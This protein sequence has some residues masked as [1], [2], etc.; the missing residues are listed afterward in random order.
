M[1]NATALPDPI[2]RR[3]GSAAAEEFQVLL[4][5]LDL[6]EGFVLI[7]LVVP[8]NNG[9]RLC[10]TALT[11][12]LAARDQHLTVIAPATPSDLNDAAATLLSLPPDPQRGAIWL[13]A[14]A[15]PWD[16]AYPAWE[17]A[18]R[19]ALVGLN[20]ARNPL[21][22][23][24]PLPVILVGTAALIPQMRE[25]AAD[26]W[27]VRSLSLRIEPGPEP[28][29]E[30]REPA[31]PANWPEPPIPYNAPDPDLALRMADRLSGQDSQQRTVA[32]LLDRAGQ[33]FAARRR[34]HEAEPA[35]HKAAILYERVGQ[36]PEAAR[37][38]VEI[39]DIARVTG[40][41]AA[42]RDAYA[43]ALAIR[44]TLARARPDRADY[45]R[46]LSASY[47]KMG[48]LHSALGQHEAA[49]DAHAKALVVTETL[50]RAE[51]D[52]ADYQ[53][54]LSVSYE[55]MGDV[56]TALGQTEPARDFY[57]WNL[58]IAETLARADPDRADYQRDLGASYDRMGDLYSA[59]GQGEAAR[60]FYLKDLAIAETLARARPDRA[61]Y[62]RDLLVSYNKMGDLY[63]A[64]GQT[65]AARDAYAK[66]LAIAETLAEAEP[67]RADYQRDL[68]IALLRQASTATH[69]AGPADVKR[70]LNILETLH[71]TG[72]LAPSDEPMLAAVREMLTA[73]NEP[74]PS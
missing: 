32:Y 15:G 52:R 14:A 69:E 55:R 74:G 40:R 25:I 24:F 42:A 16:P 18:W 73:P 22:R 21:R 8:D 30:M 67:D 60:D 48:D 6:A 36:Y 31:P 4:N 57:L 51:P 2:E 54:D 35:W 53:R 13:A 70:A 47:I 28:L 50:A 46:D 41:T 9:A 61:D 66:S 56:C 37:A 5:R 3:Y 20:Q 26:L 12:W 7:V 17:L 23:T 58:A 38:W 71:A 27:S 44:E 11:D 63:R 29:Q 59:L 64:L 39:G 72:R 10:Q 45:Q 1:T 68:A 49:R 33:G 19:H 62:Q 34:W 65:E 43:K